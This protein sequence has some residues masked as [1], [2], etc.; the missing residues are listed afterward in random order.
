[1]SENSAELLQGPLHQWHVDHGAKMAEFGG[2]LMPLQY[3][4][5]GV[6]AEHTA[7]R[8]AVGLFDVSHLGK[9]EIRGAG[10]V[11]FANSCLSNDLGRIAPGSAQYT[12]ALTEEGTV[13]DDLIAYLRSDE[14]LFLIPNAANT[15]AVVAALEDARASAGAS[16]EIENLHRKFGVFA[17]QGPAANAV[18]AAVGLPQ[19]SDYMSFV[20]ATVSIGGQDIALTVCRTGYTGEIGYEVVPAWADTAVVWAA[21]AEA[22]EQAGGRPAGLGA[23]DTLRTEMGYALHGHELSTEITAVEAGVGWAVG[24]KKDA[25][26]G[27]EALTR[28]KADGAPRKS[29]GLLATDRGVPRADVDVLDAD[30]AVVGRTTSGTFSPT[31]GNGVALALVDPAVQLGDALAL[32]IRGRRLGV[33]VVKPPFVQVNVKA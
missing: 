11:A 23:R 10:A 25:F 3:D 19:P 13:T 1:M 26:W 12:L 30:G 15:T 22:V 24:W 4:G 18:M 17:V 9:A 32:D 5:G 16:V 7:V 21:L 28:Q 31:L 20:D 2:W 8:T 6:V 33:T 27:K 29:V 14:D